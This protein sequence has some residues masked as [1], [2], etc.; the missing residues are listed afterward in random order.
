VSVKIPEEIIAVTPT[1]NVNWTVAKTMA[2][3]NPPVKD[4]HGNEITQRVAEVVYTA[5]APLAD[6]MRD[7]FELSLK[8]PDTPGKTLLFPSVQTCEGR[9]GLGAGA[10][11]RAERG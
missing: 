1:V 2:A 7:T 6:D 4:S 9:D 11:R 5:K 3:L 10:R 8:L